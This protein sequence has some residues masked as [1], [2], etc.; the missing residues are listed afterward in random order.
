MTAAP[1]EQTLSDRPSEIE[2]RYSAGA[3]RPL[4][5]YMILMGTYGALVGALSALA[6]LR[7]APLPTRVP[8]ADL[9][10][11][12]VGTYRASRLIAKDSITAFLRAPFT[13]FEEPAGSGEV[14]EEVIGRGLRHAIGEWISCPFCIAVWI[15]T[16]GAFGLVMF[17]RATRLACSI[18]AAASG[19]DALQFA[20]A[21]LQDADS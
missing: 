21:R 8:A 17:P 2:R 12:T 4:G 16:V 15:A 1:R 6:R 7:R 20:H 14:N 5:S 10:L 13:R 18:L 19:S 9:A 11:L 3:E